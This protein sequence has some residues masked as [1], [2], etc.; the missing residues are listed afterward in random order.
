MSSSATE[1]LSRRQ[2]RRAFK[3][4]EADRGAWYPRWFWPSFAAPAVL[5]QSIFFIL[6]FYVIIAVAFGTYDALRSPVP[7]FQPWF[8][9]FAQ[10]QE[11]LS[12]IFGSDAKY[13][14]V[15]LRTFAFIIIA[16]MLCLV[17]GYT[18][19]YFVA[20][21]GGRRK[22]LFLVL[23]IAPFWINYLMRMFAWQSLLADD[24][25]VNDVF[26]F[27]PG[28]TPV[29]WLS[30]KPYTVILGLVYG[31]VPYL[32]LPVYGQLDRIGSSL[33]EAGRDLGASPWQ[34]FRRV[35][36]PLSKPALLAGVIIIMLP[37]MGDYYTNQLLSGSPKTT[38]VGNII[39]RSV[40]EP[41]R[42]ALG[43]SVVLTLIVILLV[44]MIYYMR[45]TAR[46][47]V[48]R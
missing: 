3:Q 5:W 16:T 24:G 10:F 29:A 28:L 21:H 8:W 20:R 45:T 31:Y 27:V 1:H 9:D 43:A 4:L 48:D 33:L 36:L 26:A 19:A 41:G 17:I 15:Y 13:Q 34:T 35:T 7:I 46:Q 44:P 18:V 11:V 42:G 37:M 6:P 14:A 30:G 12:D 38:M 40:F 25:F 22:T 23:L 47:A 2:K 39:D 32:V